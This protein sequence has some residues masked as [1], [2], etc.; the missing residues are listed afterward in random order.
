MLKADTCGMPAW[1]VFLLWYVTV[2]G[3]VLGDLQRDE[4]CSGLERELLCLLL[5]LLISAESDAVNR[6]LPSCQ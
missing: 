1:S 6:A 5:I 2:L 3:T 4:R